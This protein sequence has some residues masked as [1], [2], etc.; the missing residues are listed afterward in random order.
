MLASNVDGTVA[1]ATSASYA[2]N[3]SLLDGTPQTANLVFSG[4]VRG[5]VGALSIISNTASMDCSTGNFFT[6]SMPAGG[7]V[8]LNPTNIAAG[9]TVN[10][11]TTQNATAATIEFPTSTVKFEDATAF[12]VSTGS[13]AV[14][15]MTFVSFDGSTINAVGLKNFS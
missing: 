8:H 11:R 12:T 2:T 9:Q 7:V 3:A 14:D 5:E 1:S 13:G 6:L 10:L 15:V 4:S